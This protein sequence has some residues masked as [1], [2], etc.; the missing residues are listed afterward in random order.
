MMESK[1]IVALGFV[2]LFG[3]V[4]IPGI[5][6]TVRMSCY[7]L[8]IIPS[9]LASCL[10]FS[11][12]YNIP[13]T[14]HS[15]LTTGALSVVAWHLLV[16]V[17]TFLYLVVC[18]IFWDEVME[19]FHTDGQK[20]CSLTPFLVL[21][22]F[23]FSVLWFQALRM[24]FMI[25]PYTFLNHGHLTWPYLLFVP[26]FTITGQGMSYSLSGTYCEL[27]LSKQYLF[28]LNMEVD[29][30]GLHL[31]P[32]PVGIMPVIFFLIP[33]L[34]IRVKK[35]MQLLRNK[36][37]I[38]PYGAAQQD[39]DPAQLSQLTQELGILFVTYTIVFILNISFVA[40]GS[41]IFHQYATSVLLDFVFFGMP[42]Y[43]LFA[44]PDIIQFLKLKFNQ[45]RL[46]QGYF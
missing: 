19:K 39:S 17:S 40:Y 21:P 38:V 5:A 45:I 13:D 24:W 16:S 12:Y 42:F 31:I 34:Y 37:Q 14:Q 35:H 27:N 9:C 28:K 7:S 6:L 11:Y 23:S 32:I 10:I 18:S 2:L 30:G 8:V 41:T 26:L 43:W 1:R 25:S 33:E 3:L 36:N 46:N 44:S 20:M 29:I 22:Y 15:L 4:N